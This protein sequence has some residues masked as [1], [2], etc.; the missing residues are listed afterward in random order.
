[1]VAAATA[2][3]YV[4]FAASVV[5]YIGGHRQRGSSDQSAQGWTAHLMREPGGQLLVAAVGVGVVVAGAVLLV[6]GV[7][8]NVDDGV[9]PGLN[10]WPRRALDV[11]GVVGFVAR[12]VVVGV[13]GGFLVDAAVTFDPRQAKGLD[14]SLRSL[15]RAPGGSVVL[16]AAAAGLAAFG[17]WSIAVGIWID[18]PT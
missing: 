8:G 7:R 15:A 16:L 3:I 10:G 13:A 12:G 17:L 2:V 1:L 11:L 9:R 4:G 14:G 5:P 6:Q 18:A